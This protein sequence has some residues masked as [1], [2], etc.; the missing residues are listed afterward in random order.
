MK[1]KRRWQESKSITQYKNEFYNSSKLS[2]DSVLSSKLF[3]NTF[4]SIS[5]FMSDALC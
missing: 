4:D 3:K 2:I 5:Q 1:N